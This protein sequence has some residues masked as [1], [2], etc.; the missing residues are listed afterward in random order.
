MFKR[1]GRRQLDEWCL[2]WV[3]DPG[4]WGSLPPEGVLGVQDLPTEVALIGLRPGDP[5]FVAPDGTVDQGLL[6]FVRS[7]EFRDGAGDQAEL[8]DGYPTVV[9]FPVLARSS[10]EASGEAGLGGLP[11]LEMSGSAE[12]APD[13][14]GP[15]AAR[16]PPAVGTPSPTGTTW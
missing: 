11:A 8:R 10:V 2:V 3:P 6:D 15:R 4:Q 9:D 5:V 1:Q 7:V 13:Q 12:P 16:C 14:P